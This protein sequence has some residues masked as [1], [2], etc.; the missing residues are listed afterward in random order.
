VR[1]ILI[2]AVL[3]M[4]AVA[5]VWGLGS[6]GVPVRPAPVASPDTRAAVPTATPTSTP[7]APRSAPRRVRAARCPVGL[8][9]CRTVRGR[10][11]FVES[12]DPDGDGDLHVVLAGGRVTAPGITSVDVAPELRPSRDP[13]IGDQMSAAGQVQRGSFGQSQVHAVE[14]HVRRSRQ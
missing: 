14:L 5:A 3:T 8:P 1:L 10:V 13:R 7:A 6:S 4:L 9:G 2:V 12:V 11:I